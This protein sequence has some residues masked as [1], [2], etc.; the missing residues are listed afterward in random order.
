LTRLSDKLAGLTFVLTGTMPNLKRNE[1]AALI[2][3]RR[4]GRR[5]RKQKDV[6][7]GRGEDP[8]SKLTKAQELGV[9]LLDERG[10]LA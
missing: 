7:R 2:E 10:L 9:P 5:Q 1:A 4:K 6:F 3:T 8:G